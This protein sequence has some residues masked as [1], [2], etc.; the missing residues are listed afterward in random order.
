MILVIVTLIKIS[1]KE[2]RNINVRSTT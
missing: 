2:E 1:N